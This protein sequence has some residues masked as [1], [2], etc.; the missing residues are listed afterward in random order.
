MSN[1]PGARRAKHEQRERYAEM[2]RK[3]GPDAWDPHCTEESP[4]TPVGIEDFEARE[5]AEDEATGFIGSS[6]F[7]DAA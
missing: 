3:D 4:D 6:W 7:G 1:W 5:R 2:I